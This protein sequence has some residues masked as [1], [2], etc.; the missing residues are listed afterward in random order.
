M[1]KIIASIFIVIL[2]SIV[3]NAQSTVISGSV[4][5]PLGKPVFNAT[6]VLEGKNVGARTDDEGKFKFTATG[7]GTFTL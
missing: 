2:V 1:K 3:G 6:I 7:S 4:K 5:D